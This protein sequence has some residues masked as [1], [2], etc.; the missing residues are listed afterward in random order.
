MEEMGV[1]TS[2]LDLGTVNER[3]MD[4][5]LASGGGVSELGKLAGISI[6]KDGDSHTT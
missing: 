2:R 1:E 3:M 5:P 4:R 6:W